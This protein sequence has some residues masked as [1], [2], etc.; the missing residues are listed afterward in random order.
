MGVLPRLG[1]TVMPEYWQT[2]GA[3][4]VLDNL[5]RAG[6]DAVATSPYVLAPAADGQG[7]R[8]PPIDGGAG[9]VRLLDRALWGRRALWVRTA[10]AFVPD[11]ALYRGL[12]YQPPEPDALTAAEGARISAAI[13]AA[14]RRGLQ[15][16]LQVQAAIPP[17][18][19]V[20]F[21]APRAQDQP[22]LPDGTTL[23][24]RLDGNAS[25]AAPAVADYLAALLRD[26]V[27][28]YPEI[29]AIR[30]DWPEMPPYA[31][32]ASLFD[33]S[34]PAMRAAA[35]L[36]FAIGEMR[37]DALATLADIRSGAAAAAILATPP[38]TALAALLAARPGLAEL[39]RFK[40]ALVAGFL[41]DAAAV[42]RDA[43]GGRVGLLPQ[44]FPAP[45]CLASGFDPAAVA[46]H[47]PAIAVKLYTMH[48]PM[49]ARFW[50]AGLGRPDEPA[51][52]CALALL[53]DLT[54]APPDAARFRYPE[55]EE[56]HPVGAGAQARKLA[57]AR[58]A[59]GSVPV[60]A[61]AH[62]YGPLADVAAR[63]ALAWEASEQRVFVNR[64]GYLSDAKLA[65]IG[66]V[67]RGNGGDRR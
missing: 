26:L 15:V 1:I 42:L 13:A 60:Y 3:E 9:G 31:V 24:G 61:I 10:P 20:Q 63:F 55:P 5:A 56:A 62:G 36:G 38:E 43:S 16:Q 65:A 44:G 30:L 37:R 66:A 14:K 25:L 6:A 49:I 46:P 29:D 52:L 23:P 12:P 34:E 18:Y 40:R 45:L 57:S 32:A 35:R 53:L 11:R 59:A 21:G 51:L 41:A 67:V 7:G 19:R 28:A 64:Y 4:A 17:G 27:R 8:E 48:W 50:A 58:A 2:E 39:I 54:D 33:F 47:V 22:L